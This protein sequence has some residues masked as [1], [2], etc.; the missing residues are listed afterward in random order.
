MAFNFPTRSNRLALAWLVTALPA[1]ASAAV[2]IPSPSSPFVAAMTG[3]WT[4]DGDVVIPETPLLSNTTMVLAEAGSLP[5]AH[6]L[7][8]SSFGS[9]GFSAQTAGGDDLEVYGGTLW[10]DAF[11][12][13]GGSGGGLATISTRVTGTISGASEMSFA[14][15]VSDQPFD[16]DVI[17]ATV[18]ATKGFWKLAL[19]NANRLMFTGVVNGCD[20]PGAS[21]NCGHMPFQEYSG[22]FGQDLTATVPFTYDQPLYVVSILGG[23]AFVGGG[24][25]SF[26]NSADFGITAPSGA[27]ISS[28]TGTPYAAAVPEPATWGLWAV[29]LALVVARRRRAT[30]A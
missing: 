16:Y 14:L 15:Y 13:S 26:L 17:M 7:Y 10:S 8:R 21:R 1:V 23:S 27:T 2:A 24:S 29:G 4:S 11:T 6:G 3:V 22:A 5:S 25:A 18:S 30:D 28:L 12:L 19:P 20:Q 9:N